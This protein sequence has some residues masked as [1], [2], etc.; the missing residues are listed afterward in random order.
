MKLGVTDVEVLTYADRFGG[1][2]KTIGADAHKVWIWG[3]FAVA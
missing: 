2:R 3:G 1:L